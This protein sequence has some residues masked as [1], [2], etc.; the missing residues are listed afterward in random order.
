MNEYLF[1]FG[2]QGNAGFE[3]FL[4]YLLLNLAD[5]FTSGDQRHFMPSLAQ[6]TRVFEESRLA[7][8]W[9][10]NRAA[11]KALNFDRREKSVTTAN[12][13]AYY[14]DDLVETYHLLDALVDGTEVEDTP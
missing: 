7:Q 4:D 12:Y 5:S 3:H 6:L 14:K 9:Q 10:A 13:V 2:F 8:Y 1:D 11:I